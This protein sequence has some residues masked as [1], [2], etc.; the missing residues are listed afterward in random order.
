MKRIPFF[1]FACLVMPMTAFIS[2][3]LDEKSDW[4]KQRDADDSKIQQYFTAHS[5]TAQK[6]SK[7]FYYET[8]VSN[9]QGTA[10]KEND[11]V[12]FY[13][14]MSTLDGTLVSQI[15]APTDTALRCKLLNNSIAPEAIDYGMALMKTGET[16]R[17]YV[18]SYLAYGDYHNDLFPARSIFIIEVQVTNTQSESSVYD[19]QLDSVNRY[20]ASNYTNAQKFADGL[21]YI[22]T[23]TGTGNKPVD[24]DRIS[25]NFTRKYLDGKVIK[26]TGSTPVTLYLNQG[27]MVPG[28]EEG[29]KLMKA[30]GKAILVMPSSIAFK[31]SLCLVPE[32]IRADLLSQGIISSEVKPY[33]MI[34]YEVELV[35]VN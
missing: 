11:V 10:L 25:I 5:I 30:G 16:F 32:K 12:D 29:I 19:A 4:E 2:S 33:S 31:Q 13:Y 20:V 28:L 18:P 21:N 6:H 15:S 7:G 17:F 26:T 1:I 8:V 3:C 34:Y 14:K 9:P 23:Q 27:Q 35:S 24:Y 22:E